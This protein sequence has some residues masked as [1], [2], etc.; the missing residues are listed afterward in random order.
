MF[1]LIYIYIYN[2][3]TYI[4]IRT[5]RGIDK[6]YIT[7]ANSYDVKSKG[8]GNYYFVVPFL[9]LNISDVDSD[10]IKRKK[11]FSIM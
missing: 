7:Q 1:I 5:R 6:E 9:P 4:P 10:A 3:S 2:Y 11:Y 8:W